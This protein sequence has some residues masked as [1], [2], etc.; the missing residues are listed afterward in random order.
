MGGAAQGMIGAM[1]LRFGLDVPPHERRPV[2][3]YALPGLRSV[4]REQL[5]SQDLLRHIDRR[6]TFAQPLRWI[7]LSA[8]ANERDG[9][10]WFD[11]I[12]DTGDGGNATYAVA[13][14]ALASRLHVDGL[15]PGQSLPESQL[16]IL[17]GDLAY[18]NASPALYQYRLIEMF[19]AARDAASTLQPWPEGAS[20]DAP[21]GRDHKLMAAIP[22]NHDWID[23]ASTFCRTFVNREKSGLVAARTPQQHTYFACRL[24]HRWFVLGFDFALSGDL[25]RAQFEAF[26]ALLADVPTGG[27]LVLIYPEPYWTRALGDGA[28]PAFPRR[29]QRLEYAM[30][31]RGL[32]IR[33]RLAGD[34]HHYVRER[35]SHDDGHSTDLV[36]CGC[37][38]AFGHG[39]HLRESTTPKALSVTQQ[40]TAMQPEMRGRLCVGRVDGPLRAPDAAYPSPAVSRRAALGNLW[41]LFRLDGRPVLESNACFVLTLGIGHMLSA[42]LG[43]AASPA[44]AGALNWL[45]ALLTQPL[46][47]GALALV[48]LMAYFTAVDGDPLHADG[49]TRSAAWGLVALQVLMS[50]GLFRALWPLADEGWPQ[51]GHAW[52]RLAAYGVGILIVV[53]AASGLLFGGFL[54]LMSAVFGR[55]INNASSALASEDHKGFLR[56]RVSAQRLDAYMLGCDRVPR[57][58]AP[59]G[60]GARPYWH[61]APGVPPAR[62]RVVDHFKIDGPFAAQ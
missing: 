57:R 50:Y 17:G 7:D 51:S 27:N 8:L 10:F 38:G 13:R 44:G 48:V 53:T 21:I 25:D 55:V 35:L 24:P 4:A 19:E 31:S 46:A 58:W 26:E 3:W 1:P 40:A 29:Y 34:L 20:D 23:S 54:A 12:A 28:D 36:V 49:T 6:E 32:H 11:F 30:H 18:P 60:E 43:A 61:E 47:L 42:A 56:M 2:A 39:T 41:A 33:L 52:S 15:D 9:E 62:W 16:L 14:A 37:G 5:W 22:Q 59:R 45:W